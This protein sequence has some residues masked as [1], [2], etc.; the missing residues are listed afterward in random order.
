MDLKEYFVSKSRELSVK[1]K[2]YS[3]GVK[4]MASGKGKKTTV[5]GVLCSL[6]FDQFKIDISYVEKGISSYAQQTIWVDFCLDADKS[7]PFS[8]YDILAVTEPENFNCYTYT[9]VDSQSLMKS[10]FEELQELLL[11][12][13]PEFQEFLKSG[14]NK[15]NLIIRQRETLNNYFGDNVLEA[16]E[17]LG[18]QADRLIDA[19]IANFH[20]A[21]IEAAVLGSQALFYSGKTDKALK[22][23]RKSKSRSLY[24]DNLLAYLEKGGKAFEISETAKNASADKGAVRHGGGVKGGLR[25][26]GYTFLYLIPVD[27][28]LCVFYYIASVLLY[29]GSVFTYGIGEGLIFV[30]FMGMLMAIA[31]A[32]KKMWKNENTTDNSPSAVHTPKS[33]ATDNLLKYFIIAGETIALLGVMTC[34][35]SVTPF[36]NDRFSYGVDDFPLS[37]ETCRYESVD[38]FAVVEGYII[39]ENK[40]TEDKY[41]AVKTKSGAVIDLYNSTCFTAETFT[42]REEFFKE[43]GIEIKKV[44]TVEE[45]KGQ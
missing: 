13:V 21:Q 18:G 32:A 15:N 1:L 19:M 11:R 34:V 4:K 43:K 45:M 20:R 10:C 36:Y 7:I 35:F 33:S 26:L 16:G 41:I 37:Q 39:G 27:V 29:K 23:L 14:V 44:K 25:L 17:A 24:Q 22:V 30:P 40:F 38:Y 12:V 3:P 8:L 2:T 9:Y 31:L 5:T 28:A 42:E 6:D